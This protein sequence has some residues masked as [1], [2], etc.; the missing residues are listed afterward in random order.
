MLSWSAIISPF[1]EHYPPSFKKVL[2]TFLQICGPDAGFLDDPTCLASMGHSQLI[3]FGQVEWARDSS[4]AN[5]NASPGNSEP[6]VV[7]IG[8]G[9][10][11][12]SLMWGCESGSW[13][14]PLPPGEWK[15][16]GWRRSKLCLWDQARE[17]LS[18]GLPGLAPVPASYTSA[19]PQLCQSRPSL[20]W[21]P[22]KLGSEPYDRIWIAQGLS[23]ASQ[24]RWVDKLVVHALSSHP[25]VFEYVRASGEVWGG[26]SHGSGFLKS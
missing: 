6:T 8:W 2:P 12:F 20:A 19:L 17:E 4:W 10:H 13:L 14:L 11:S 3:F 21:A 5:Q 15:P 9:K 7:G 18:R 25:V 22:Y 1:W 26:A 24:D 23:R 16:I